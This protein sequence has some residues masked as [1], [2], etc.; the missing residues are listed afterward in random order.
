MTLMRLTPA[1][2]QN[3]TQSREEHVS[4]MLFGGL[5]RK[6]MVDVPSYLFCLSIVRT[7]YRRSWFN[8]KYAMENNTVFLDINEDF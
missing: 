7:Y 3:S 8:W 5:L 2:V 1:T 6:K 4:H